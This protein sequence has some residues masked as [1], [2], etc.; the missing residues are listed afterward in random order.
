LAWDGDLPVGFIG[1]ETFDRWTNWAVRSEVEGVVETIDVRQ[2]E[3][4][5]WSIRLVT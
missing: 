1:C 5:T 4:A 3:S 2:V